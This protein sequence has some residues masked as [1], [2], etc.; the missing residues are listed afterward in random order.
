[1]R[2]PCQELRMVSLGC[3]H[4]LPGL[5]EEDMNP[6]EGATRGEGGAASLSAA[7]MGPLNCVCK[8]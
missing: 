1:M 7:L 5:L 8:F 2:E 3:R 6:G 4:R